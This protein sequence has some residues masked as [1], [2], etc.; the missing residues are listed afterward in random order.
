MHQT[1]V[2]LAAPTID[3]TLRQ[4]I[5]TDANLT[6]AEKILNGISPYI[7]T[8]RTSKANQR[9]LE[10]W[11][12][13]GQGGMIGALR[14]SVNGLIV[15]SASQDMNASP[16]VYSHKLIL[17][18]CR[19]SGSKS[20]VKAL[21]DEVVKFQA[22]SP[23]LGDYAIDVVASMISAPTADDFSHRVER[24]SQFVVGEENNM[25]SNFDCSSR[26][27]DELKVQ[28]EIAVAKLPPKD[29]VRE[30]IARV[31]RRVNTLVQPYVTNV[32]NEHPDINHHFV[33]DAHTQMVPNV[34]L[35]MDDLTGMNGGI[36]G[37]G[38]MSGLDEDDLLGGGDANDYLDMDDMMEGF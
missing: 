8:R 24:N 35:G 20:V 9:E 25:N 6:A 3:R 23:L 19:L 7:N 34:G 27:L 37:G 15:W 12:G 36:S 18:C 14:S 1:V 31:R 17:T 29:P 38:L 4:L 33:A 13:G 30:A 28:E 10:S 2:S 16:P 32:V 11:T 21:I 5:H 22:Q 26:L